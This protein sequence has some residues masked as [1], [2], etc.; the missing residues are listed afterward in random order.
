[1]KNR[2]YIKEIFGFTTWCCFFFATLF[3]ANLNGKEPKQK[4]KTKP[5]QLIKNDDPIIDEKAYIVDGD[6]LATENI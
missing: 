4:Q 5:D 1:M 3:V 2:R 6:T